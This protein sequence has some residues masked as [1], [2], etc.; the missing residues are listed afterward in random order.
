MVNFSVLLLL[1]KKIYKLI[2][3]FFI[4]D[5][6]FIYFKATILILMHSLYASLKMSHSFILCNQFSEAISFKIVIC[7]AFASNLH[8]RNMCSHHF[9]PFN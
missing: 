6:L 2:S 7:C 1:F 9:L 5:N 3:Y 8:Q 4:I